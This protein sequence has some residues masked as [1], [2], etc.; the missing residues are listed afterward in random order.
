MK[1]TPSKS[2]NPFDSD[3]SDGSE[4][5]FYDCQEKDHAGQEKAALPKLRSAQLNFD[6]PFDDV[7]KTSFPS[8]LALRCTACSSEIVYRTACVAI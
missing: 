7:G 3:S 6:N 4:E 2:T 5:N 8:S 1:R